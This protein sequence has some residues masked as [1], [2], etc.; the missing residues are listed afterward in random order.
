MAFCSL[1][2]FCLHAFFSCFVCVSLSFSFISTPVI[3]LGATVIQHGLISMNSISNYP[4]SNTVI[5]RGSWWTWSFGSHCSIQHMMLWQRHSFR[6]WD[7]CDDNRIMH[8]SETLKTLFAKDAEFYNQ[9][10]KSMILDYSVTF[11][12]YVIS[13]NQRIWLIHLSVFQIF[14]C[15][16]LLRIHLSN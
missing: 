15:M 11:Q 7:A 10:Y 14:D 1:Y 3:E 6:S 16:S 12:A 2:L 4:I 8:L 13:L 5:C 9:F